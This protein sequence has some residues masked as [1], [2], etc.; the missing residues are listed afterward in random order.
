LV[1]IP[2][3]T[4]VEQLKGVIR[5]KTYGGQDQGDISDTLG[6]VGGFRLKYRLERNDTPRGTVMQLSYIE[7]I[8]V[9]SQLGE[10]ME[11]ALAPKSKFRDKLEMLSPRQYTI[12]VW[13]YPDSFAEFRRLKKDLYNLGY[14]VAARPLEDGRPIGASP[15]GTKSSAQ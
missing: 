8:P 14:A 7:F 2:F 11:M 10:P 6:P 9:A 4:L 5:D 13:T 1:Y 12:T 15:Q 3:E